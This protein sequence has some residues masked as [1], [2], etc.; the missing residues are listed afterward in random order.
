MMA[1]AR[2]ALEL[3][4]FFVFAGV[5][6]YGFGR[7]FRGDTAWLALSAVAAYVIA[8]Q[9]ARVQDGWPKRVSRQHPSRR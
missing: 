4:L 2:G 7:A 6:V 8:K 9:M 3:G 5:G 1:R